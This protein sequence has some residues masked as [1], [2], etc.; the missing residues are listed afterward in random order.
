M[1]IS[2][3]NCQWKFDEDGKNVATVSKLR[4]L[5]FSFDEGS[6]KA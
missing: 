5:R 2:E 1:E 6:N 3:L 4:S